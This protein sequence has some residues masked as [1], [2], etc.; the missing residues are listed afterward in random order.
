MVVPGLLVMVVEGAVVDILRTVFVV[1]MVVGGA[2]LRM[3]WQSH[4]CDK[5]PK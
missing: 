4:V 5:R 2:V 1:V 3:H